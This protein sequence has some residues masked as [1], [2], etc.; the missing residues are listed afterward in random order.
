MTNSNKK[1]IFNDIEFITGAHNFSQIPNNHF[2]EV[3][4]IGASNVGKSSIINAIFGK[5][6]TIVSSTPGRTQQLNFFK[7]SG[8]RDGFYVVDLPGYGFAEASA[9]KISHWQNTTF[10][11]LAKSKNLQKVFLLIDAIK[12][13]KNNDIEVIE[14]FLENN[15]LFQII[16]TKID[17]INL[18]EQQI[19]KEKILQQ[20]SLFKTPEQKLILS[21]SSK[22]YGI[23]DIKL[24]IIST[25]K[26]L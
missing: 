3:A 4:F 24:E 9:K 23:N 13:L 1:I 22:K 15:I 14:Y 2:P 11:Y 20:L 12:G 5:K 17:K 8:F 25:L 21:S 26:K 18:T 6:I 7:V 10:E 19:V 16:L